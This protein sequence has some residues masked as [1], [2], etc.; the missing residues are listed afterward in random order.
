MR[1]VSAPGESYLASQPDLLLAFTVLKVAH[2]G[3][4]LGTSQ[5]FLE[6]VQRQVAV[7][8]VGAGNRFGHPGPEALTRLREARAQVWGTD[9]CGEVEIATDGGCCGCRRAR[10]APAV[11]QGHSAKPDAR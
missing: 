5:R 7:I 8:R 2:R 11:E 3:A 9:Q 10:A 4:R 1:T 6:A